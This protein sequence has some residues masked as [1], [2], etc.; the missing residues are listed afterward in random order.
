MIKRTAL[1]IVACLLC[2]FSFSCAEPGASEKTGQSEE[3]SLDIIAS[4]CNRLVQDDSFLQ[5]TNVIESDA[6][7]TDTVYQIDYDHIEYP[8]LPDDVHIHKPGALNITVTGSTE[9]PGDQMIQ[10]FQLFEENHGPFSECDYVLVNHGE[11]GTMVGYHIPFSVSHRLSAYLVKGDP[12]NATYYHF[13]FTEP[14]I[15]I[16]RTM[17]FILIADGWYVV[18]FY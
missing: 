14:S 8:N 17:E 1:W 6:Q 16:K 12:V 11:Y 5:L 4:K 18:C 3:V 2:I 13:G 15:G 7:N 9:I 10:A